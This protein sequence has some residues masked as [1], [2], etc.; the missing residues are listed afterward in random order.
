MI[1]HL[2][3]DDFCLENAGPAEEFFASGYLA[4][5][6]NPDSFFPSWQGFLKGGVGAAFGMF[7]AEQLVGAIGGLA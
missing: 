6:F 4:G 5:D 1:R 7:H 2:T 3:A